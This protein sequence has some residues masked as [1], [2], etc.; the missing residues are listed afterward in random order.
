LFKNKPY[1]AKFV[2]SFPIE[3]QLS[4]AL[5][6]G[7]PIISFFWGDGPSYR[8]GQGSRGCRNPDRWIR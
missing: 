8:Q 7:V 6:Q 3:K 4:V 2:L 1:G 5:D